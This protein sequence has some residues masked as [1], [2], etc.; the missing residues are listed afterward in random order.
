MKSDVIGGQLVAKQLKKEKIDTIF[1]LIGNQ[2]SPILVNLA[3]YGIKV[4]HTRHEQGAVHMADGWAQVN[5]KPGVAIVSGG[6]GFFNTFTG[7]IK[8]YFAQTPLLIITGAVVPQS[9]DKGVLQDVEQISLIRP[10]T[11]W[12]RTVYDASRIPEYIARALQIAATGRRGPVV[13]EIPISVLKQ[14]TDSVID[15]EGADY[16]LSQY[17]I[18]L[19][20]TE[21]IDCFLELIESSERP[22]IVVGDDVYYSN[23][24]EEL[25]EFVETTQIPVFT[26]N[27]ARGCIPDSHNLCFGSG[28]VLEAGSNLYA[29]QNAD[30]IIIIGLDIDYQ[31]GYLDEPIFNSGQKFIAINKEVRSILDGNYKPHLVI[32]GS[33]NKV[34][35]QI[36][37]RVKELSK[38]FSFDHWLYDLRKNYRNYWNK[39]YEEVNQSSP[40]YPH[41]LKCINTIQ[42]FISRDAIIVLDGS[43]AMFWG[44]L[45]FQ[46]N[47]PGQL[48]IGPD[49]IFGPMGAGVA[50]AIGAKVAQ[51][52]KEVILYTGDGSF[53]FNAIEIDTAARFNLPITVFVHNDQA[54]GFTKSTQEMLYGKTEASDLGLVRYDKVVEALGGFGALVTDFTTLEESI[55]RAKKSGRT[56]CINIVVDKNADS[57]GAHY[58][59]EIL[60]KQK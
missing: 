14:H 12:A 33:I 4:I 41:P 29:Y 20:P 39:L 44:A 36:S 42:K 53:G 2:V 31:M 45:C 34:L 52:Q 5:K 56:A 48:I 25:I 51:P 47:Y 3:E 19:A 10:Y 21:M 59:S 49:G 37:S 32:T 7:I 22:V 18:S 46:C 30:T 35:S 57:P 26:V 24:E 54:W 1:A 16:N 28:R 50:L 58:F 27:K 9:K 6:P 11:K 43:N 40:S 13:L 60:K 17:D 15:N 23:S 55:L 38:R 8:A